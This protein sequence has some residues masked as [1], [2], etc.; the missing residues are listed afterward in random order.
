MHTGVVE[1]DHEVEGD[2]EEEK[3][4]DIAQDEL[5]GEYIVGDID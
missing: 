2:E 4:L 3:E 5:D 1:Q